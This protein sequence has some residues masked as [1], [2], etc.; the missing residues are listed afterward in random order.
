VRPVANFILRVTGAIF[1]AAERI[2]GLSGRLLDL[3][4]SVQF[5]VAGD[6][7]G[8]FFDGALGLMSRALESILI[9][10]I[11][12]RLNQINRGSSIKFLGLS[13]SLAHR[14]AT[15]GPQGQ[16]NQPHW[17]SLA[18]TSERHHMANDNDSNPN[19]KKPGEKEPGKYHFNPGNQSGKTVEIDKAAARKKANADPGQTP[20]E[21]LDKGQKP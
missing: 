18:K 4:F 8:R 12:L 21:E 11:F 13:S 10:K 1:G 2:L 17:V 5:G 9:H 7:A 19:Q 3:A 15:V 6:F 14:T 20:R 16:R